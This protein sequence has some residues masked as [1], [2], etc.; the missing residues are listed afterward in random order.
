[1]SLRLIRKKHTPPL[2]EI[3]PL[4]TSSF[5]STHCRGPT[6][7][8]AGPQ[9]GDRYPEIMVS[10]DVRTA[11]Q[12]LKCPEPEGQSP[13][14]QSSTSSTLGSCTDCFCKA[15]TKHHSTRYNPLTLSSPVLFFFFLIR[16]FSFFLFFF[17]KTYVSYTCYYTENR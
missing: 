9:M 14:A 15:H 8:I 12:G 7:P 10:S 16:N 6:P 1:M 5:S 4:L 11:R 13:Q 3:R 17:S 2:N